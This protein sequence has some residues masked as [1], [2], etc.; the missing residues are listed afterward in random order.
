M[1]VTTFPGG[2]VLKMNK[3]DIWEMERA[4]QIFKTYESAASSTAAF[5]LSSSKW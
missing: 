2:S 4:Y 1:I 3:S 5:T